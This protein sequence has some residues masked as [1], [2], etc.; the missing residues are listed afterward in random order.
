MFLSE[1]FKDWTTVFK[2][3]THLNQIV[4]NCW[5][6]ARNCEACDDLSSDLLSSTMLS[7]DKSK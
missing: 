2:I 6:P 4:C 7:L 1:S 5:K 3:E